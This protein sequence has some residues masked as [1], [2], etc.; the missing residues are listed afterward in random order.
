MPAAT[1]PP[2]PPAGAIDD[3]DDLFNYDV[4]DD[5]VFRDF[6]PN[7]DAPPQPKTNGNAETQADL[8][9]EEIQVAKA[10]KPVAK[11]DEG[12]WVILCMQLCHLWDESMLMGCE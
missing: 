8:G 5:D 6:V 1:T 10:R 4:A 7:M 3:L 12:R 2:P 11:L 9:L